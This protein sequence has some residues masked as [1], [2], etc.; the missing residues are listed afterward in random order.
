MTLVSF[1]DLDIALDHIRISNCISI[2]CA[3]DLGKRCFKT[4]PANCHVATLTSLRFCRSSSSLSLALLATIL[5]LSASYWRWVLS[6]LMLRL[7]ATFTRAVISFMAAKNTS[8][9]DNKKRQHIT[10]NLCIVQYKF[11]FVYSLISVWHKPATDQ[12]KML[13]WPNIKSI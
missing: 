7:R 12:I 10:V 9:I 11:V 3:C 13:Q 2:N 5:F 8:N 4:N 1:F 6:M